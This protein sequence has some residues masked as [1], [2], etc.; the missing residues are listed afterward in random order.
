MGHWDRRGWETCAL[1]LRKAAKRE[2][3]IARRSIHHL[4]P[5]ITLRA[6][7]DVRDGLGAASVYGKADS[8]G[9]ARSAG[10]PKPSSYKVRPSECIRLPAKSRNCSRS[11]AWPG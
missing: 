9:E 11:E 2:I 1:S 7:P 4:T 8:T 5:E 3:T 6:G 10:Q